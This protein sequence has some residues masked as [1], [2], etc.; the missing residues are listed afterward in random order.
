MVKNPPCDAGDIGLIPG[1]RR[2]HILRGNSVCATPQ[3]NLMS[4]RLGATTTEQCA[5]I[6]EAH[7]P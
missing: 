6:T 3:L 2:F 5:V 1:L 7:V 4:K